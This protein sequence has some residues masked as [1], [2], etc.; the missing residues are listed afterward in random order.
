MSHGRPAG[1]ARAAAAEELS[2]MRC[3]RRFDLSGQPDRSDGEMVQSDDA[4]AA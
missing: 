2:E 1:S 3:R 4:R